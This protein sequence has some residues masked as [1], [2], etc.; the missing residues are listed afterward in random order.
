VDGDLRFTITLDT[1]ASTARFLVEPTDGSASPRWESVVSVD[2]VPNASGHRPFDGLV[3]VDGTDDDATEAA[4]RQLVGD[5]VRTALVEG[6]WEDVDGYFRDGTYVLHGPMFTDG[7]ESVR[8][9]FIGLRDAGAPFLI[10]DTALLLADGPYV[11]AINRHDGLD[12]T[13]A[14][15]DLWRVDDGAIVEHWDAT[16]QLDRPDVDAWFEGVA[17]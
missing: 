5:Y 15:W 3:P 8:S 11:L 14:Y 16:M 12:T 4:N 1:T 9:F 7:L 17:P 13:T 6:R 10:A 2:D